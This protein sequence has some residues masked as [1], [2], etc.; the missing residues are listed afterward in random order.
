MGLLHSA[1][2]NRALSGEVDAFFKQWKLMMTIILFCFF[3]V[4]KFVNTKMA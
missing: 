2:R 3:L 1:D 4:K